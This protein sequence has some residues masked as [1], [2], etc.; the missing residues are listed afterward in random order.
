M[1]SMDD[2]NDDGWGSAARAVWDELRD[3]RVFR[4]F[5]IVAF[6]AGLAYYWWLSSR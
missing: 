2:P 6:L 4:V 1:A 3:S 5:R